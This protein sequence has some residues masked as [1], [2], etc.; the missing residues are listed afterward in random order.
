MA[1]V[2]MV[3]FS[4]TQVDLAHENKRNSIFKKLPFLANQHCINLFSLKVP[5]KNSF[6]KSRI[7][8]C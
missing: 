8:N 7:K 4:L 1:F 6:H 3:F 5:L 2:N